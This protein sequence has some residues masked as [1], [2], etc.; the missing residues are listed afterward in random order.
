VGFAPHTLSASELSALLEAERA[1]SPFLSFRDGLG[2]LRLVRLSG[3]PL[4]IGRAAESDV[5][6]DWDREVSRAHAQLE[7]L[8]DAWVVVDDGLSRN[9]CTVNTEPLRGRRRLA[10][11]DVIRVGATS[12]TFHAAGPSGDT[13]AAAHPAA[14]AKLTDAERRVLVALCRPLLARTGAAPTSNPAI[15]DELC[16]SVPSV[17]THLRSLFAKLA[18]EDMAQNEKR[19]QLVG[20]AIESGLVSLRD[21]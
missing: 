4:V 2:D 14:L 8:G 3:E 21:L 11:G 16:I 5:V 1:G 20:R 17:K 19:A 7:P 13:T 18:V 10:D 6:L 12:L 9:G 15:A